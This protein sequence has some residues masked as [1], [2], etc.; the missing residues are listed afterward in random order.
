MQSFL[1]CTFPHL[2]PFAFFRRE[3]PGSSNPPC[4]YFFIQFPSMVLISWPQRLTQLWTCWTCQLYLLKHP[5]LALLN[6]GCA[7]QLALTWHQLNTYLGDLGKLPLSTLKRRRWGK[8]VSSVPMYIAV[9]VWLELKMKVVDISIPDRQEELLLPLPAK[10]EESVPLT[11]FW[12]G[13]Q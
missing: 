1:H 12:Q 8:F 4:A 9:C 6:A 5:L 10:A 2:H 3:K 11:V 13:P 7:S